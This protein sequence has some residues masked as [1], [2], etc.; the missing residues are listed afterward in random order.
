MDGQAFSIDLGERV[1]GAVE[2]EGLEVGPC[3]FVFIDE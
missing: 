3:R 1:V 2:R